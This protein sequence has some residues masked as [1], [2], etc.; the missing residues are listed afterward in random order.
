M[1]SIYSYTVRNKDSVLLP[2]DTFQLLGNNPIMKRDVHQS[3]T[4]INIG[5]INA[6]RYWVADCVNF[7]TTFFDI[8][9]QWWSYTCNSDQNVPAEHD[10]LE[11]PW[12]CHHRPWWHGIAEPLPIML[13]KGPY[14]LCVSWQDRF[15]WSLAQPN[16]QRCLTIP[17]YRN[18]QNEWSSKSSHVGQTYGADGRC[19]KVINANILWDPIL[20]DFSEQLLWIFLAHPLHWKELVNFS[21]WALLFW[22]NKHHRSIQGNRGCNIMHHLSSAGTICRPL[23]EEKWAIWAYLCWSSLKLFLT[24]NISIHLVCSPQSC[25]C[26]ATSTSKTSSC[27]HLLVQVYP[28]IFLGA[29]LSPVQVEGLDNLQ[30]GWIS[31]SSSY[32]EY[33]D[34]ESILTTNVVV[35]LPWKNRLCQTDM[36]RQLQEVILTQKGRYRTYWAAKRVREYEDGSTASILEKGRA[37]VCLQCCWDVWIMCKEHTR[38]FSSRGTPDAFVVRESLVVEGDIENLIMSPRLITCN[39][40]RTAQLLNRRKAHSPMICSFV[41]G[42]SWFSLVGSSNKICTHNSNLSHVSHEFVPSLEDPNIVSSPLIDGER[43]VHHQIRY[44][45]FYSLMLV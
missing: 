3:T 12:I 45:S 22:F 38:F 37:E 19:T 23:G 25:G 43:E 42:C 35:L 44:H 28:E 14:K 9:F 1:R 8:L 16:R 21:S 5:I 7:V 4:C 30:K 2:K 34:V 33:W 20:W 41:E 36:I 29:C 39:I 6:L 27:W 26:I 11:N 40:V 32:C 18:T 31:S 10:V 24:C 17:K 13:G 15:A